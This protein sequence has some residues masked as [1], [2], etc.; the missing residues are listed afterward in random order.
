MKTIF[1]AVRT[2]LLFTLITGLLYPAAVT[3][4]A[5]A[6][7]PRQSSGQL[8]ARDGKTVGSSLIGQ[9]FTK[10][11]YF[12]GRPSAA[13]GNGYDG[14]SSGG[15]NYGPTNQKLIDRVKAGVAKFRSENTTFPGPVPADIVTASAS[16]LDPDISPEAANAQVPRVAA[17]RGMQSGALKSLLATYVRGRTF[18]VLGSPRVDVLELNM[19]LDQIAPMRK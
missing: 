16:G 9:S 12:H 17:A 5:R 18:G 2:T 14:L 3:A 8:L 1:T 4:L 10:P 7:F 11:E 6:L 19:A 13:G 15:S